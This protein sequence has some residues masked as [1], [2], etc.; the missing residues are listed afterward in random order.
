MEASDLEPVMD[1]FRQHLITKNVA[2]DI[3]G[4]SL[5]NTP[6]PITLDKL[7]QSIQTSLV[8]KKL[9]SLQIKSTVKTALEE[10]LIKILTPKK[11]IDILREIQIA[12]SQGRITYF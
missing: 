2:A 6:I 12:K 5:S 8:G 3:A 11:T 10:A 9:S 4:N 1:I 7:C